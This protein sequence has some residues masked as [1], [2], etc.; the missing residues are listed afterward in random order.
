MIVEK[1]SFIKREES[2]CNNENVINICAGFTA[3]AQQFYEWILLFRKRFRKSHTIIKNS[4][5]VTEKALK[6]WWRL[7]H[8]L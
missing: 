4:S 7:A 6:L 3:C 2:L 1:I 5:V 8:V